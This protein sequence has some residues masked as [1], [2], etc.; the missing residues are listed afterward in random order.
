[1]RVSRSSSFPRLKSQT[2]HDRE[3]AERAQR[4]L[5]EKKRRALFHNLVF[6]T[7]A[8]LLFVAVTGT[9]WPSQ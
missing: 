3:R 6:I 5:K 8:T 2:H 4:A 1:V 7:G 9:V